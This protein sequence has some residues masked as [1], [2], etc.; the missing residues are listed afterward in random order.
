MIIKNK[1]NDILTYLEDTS[2]IKG[3]AS[4]LYIPRNLQE[5][6]EIIREASA[7]KIPLT[8]QG[9]RTGTTGG[10]VPL[11]GA[12]I[13][14]E[15]LNRIIDINHK[16]KEVRLESGITLE[17]LENELN[18]SG[19]SFKAQ[20]TESL[21]F[22]GGAVS[23]C[24]S[25]TRGFRYGSIRNYIKELSV[26][27]SD[28]SLIRVKR[29]EIFAKKRKFSFFLNNKHFAFSLPTYNMPSVKTQAGY[30]IKDNMDFIDL[31]IG[32]E[33][34]LGAISELTLSVQDSSHE[35]FD[36][37]VFFKKETDALLFVEKIQ[38]MK[39]NRKLNPSSL[40]FLDTNSLNLLRSHYSNIVPSHCAVYFEQETE[41]NNKDK[42]I[43]LWS[44]IIESCG[45]SPDKV[46]FADT[47]RER[48]KIYE[49]RHKLPELINEF[50]RTNN[51]IKLSTDI[52]VP[53]KDFKD[54]Y[55]F[56]KKTAKD[57]NINYVNFGHIGEN[58]LHFNFL[59]LNNDEHKKAYSAIL[60]FAEKAASLDGT[61]SAEHGIGKIKKPLLEVMYGKKHIEEM[62]ML[63]KYFDPSFILGRDNIF[64]KELLK[65]V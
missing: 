58:H 21:A 56:Y 15:S 47:A 46:W 48:E 4:S 50:L 3:D 29:G 16:T 34:T 2:N 6:K 8:L 65:K 43:D 63:K 1:K 25:G 52:A 61:V 35:I 19:L 32:S 45:A 7:K 41:N 30:F 51:Q 37:V 14:T 20:P 54:M 60:K 36:M 17:N 53:S 44:S 62:A 57:L 18:K 38:K 31:F 10:C 49:F 28:G 55:S 33:G 24:A 23:T 26:I 59:P 42:L 64:K 27:I 22:I 11:G 12:V 13:S 40:E 5:L 9:A 39:Q